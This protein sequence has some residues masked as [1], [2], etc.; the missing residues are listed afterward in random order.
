MSTLQ[1]S[2]RAG[3]AA[4]FYFFRWP[5]GMTLRY[6]GQKLRKGLRVLGEGDSIPVPT[7]A[8]LPGQPCYRDKEANVE[9]CPNGL[10]ENA[11]TDDPVDL[12]DASDPQWTSPRRKSHGF[13]DGFD[14]SATR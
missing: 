12:N 6:P 7:D 3:D 8:D 10:I 14:E 2:I 13:V 4:I 11:F 5:P 1:A 9:A